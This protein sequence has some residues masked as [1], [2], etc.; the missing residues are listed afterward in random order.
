M[1][2]TSV[3]MPT[4]LQYVVCIVGGNVRCVDASALKTVALRMYVA[5]GVCNTPAFLLHVMLR[6]S[7]RALS[8]FCTCAVLLA[9]CF[10]KTDEGRCESC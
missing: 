1:L 9:C 5:P 8:S 6:S 4:W 10:S 3:E 7:R 2:R